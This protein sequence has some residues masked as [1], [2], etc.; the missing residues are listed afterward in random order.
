[1]LDYGESDFAIHNYSQLYI[2]FVVKKVYIDI[3]LNRS[4][5]L[6]GQERER[7]YDS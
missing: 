7:M 4:H 6:H 5:E 3:E 1:M 2:L